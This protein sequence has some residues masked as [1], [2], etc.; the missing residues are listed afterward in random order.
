MEKQALRLSL[1]NAALQ[2]VIDRHHVDRASE[3]LAEIVMAVYNNTALTD[4]EKRICQEKYSQFKKEI[5]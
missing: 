2:K 3:R 1:G 4:P 5:A